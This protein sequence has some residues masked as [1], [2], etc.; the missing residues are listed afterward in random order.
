MNSIILDEAR[1]IVSPLTVAYAL[2][3]LIAAR[4]V[5]LILFH[6]LRNIPGPQL[7]KFTT[8]WHLY[9]CWGGRRHRKLAELHDKY[10]FY[11]L[12]L[13]KSSRLLNI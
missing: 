7:A 4:A 10:G 1:R 11:P 13:F 12:L 9:H 2:L 3:A 5:W 6:P 8:L